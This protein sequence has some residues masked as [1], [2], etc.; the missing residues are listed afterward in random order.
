MVGRSERT[1][2]AWLQNVEGFRAA[3]QADPAESPEPSALV[4]LRVALAATKADGSPDWSIRVA[5]AKALIAAGEP[6][7][8]PVVRVPPG[9]V[10]FY[11]E[12]LDS[13][14]GES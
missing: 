4:T 3:A 12:A 14:L 13:I 2:R 6:L 5:A 7:Q 9:G 10:V 8:A 1:I 11:P